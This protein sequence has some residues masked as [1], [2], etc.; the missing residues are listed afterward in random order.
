MPWRKPWLSSSP[1][2][3]LLLSLPM[4]GSTWPLPKSQTV[5]PTHPLDSSLQ[6]SPMLSLFSSL[7]PPSPKSNGVLQQ[8]TNFLRIHI[9]SSCWLT[10]FFQIPHQSNQKE[11]T[12]KVSKGMSKQFGLGIFTRGSPLRIT[13]TAGWSSWIGRGLHSV[14]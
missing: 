2:L 8:L 14:M 5:L 11:K 1:P 3:L 13:E 7:V 10:N 4:K 12:F 9:T 6:L